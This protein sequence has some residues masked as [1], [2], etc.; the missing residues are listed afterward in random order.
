MD[1]TSLSRHAALVLAKIAPLIGGFVVIASF[2]DTSG[3]VWTEA[4]RIG[5]SVG[6]GVFIA[7]V[8]AIYQN[9]NRRLESLETA[10]KTDLVPRREYDSRHGDLV[11]QL[12]RIEAVLLGR[13]Q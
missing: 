11:K 2:Q 1:M 5:M 12:D 10:A 13:K 3:N 7:L 6:L 8:G 9:L 4:W